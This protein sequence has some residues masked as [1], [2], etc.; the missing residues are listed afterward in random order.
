[1][2]VGVRDRRRPY[3][4]FEGVPSGDEFGE[5]FLEGGSDSASEFEMGVSAL[6]GGIPDGFQGAFDAADFQVV[7]VLLAQLF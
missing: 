2:I 5:F 1:M 7:V 4:F 3:V 6:T